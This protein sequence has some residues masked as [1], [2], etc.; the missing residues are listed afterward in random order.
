[1]SAVAKFTQSAKSDLQRLQWSLLLFVVLAAAGAVIVSIA[2][3]THNDKS[4]AHQQ[5]TLAR[6]EARSKA[7]R[8][9]QEEQEL[10]EKIAV[11]QKMS[12]HGFIGQEHRI[13]WIESIRKIKQARKLI[14]VRYEIGPQVPIDSD[15]VPSALNGFEI[16]SSPMR[17]DMLLLHEN[18]LLGFLSDLRAEVQGYVRV[19]S[20]DVT[21]A[22][23]AVPDHG[24]APQLQASCKL[25]WITVREKQ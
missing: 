9:S 16:M 8:A 18:D 10:R 23:G 2:S 13:D 17:L 12:A 14:D 4:A 15:V 11:Y 3:K 24:P 7:S 20:C 5:A 6:D 25:D 22:V 19:E 1:M 21:R